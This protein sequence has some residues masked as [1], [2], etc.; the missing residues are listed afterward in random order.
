MDFQISGPTTDKTIYLTPST[1]DEAY[2]LRS[3]AKNKEPLTGHLERS[4]TY[5]YIT[6]ILK[7]ERS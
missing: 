4:K 2:S 6:L 3:I 1:E 7:K 5:P